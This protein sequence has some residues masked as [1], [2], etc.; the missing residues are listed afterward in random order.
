M[1]FTVDQHFLL[2]FME[3]FKQTY[4]LAD[5]S[6]QVRQLRLT[7]VMELFQ[8]L[9]VGCEVAELGFL[10]GLSDSTR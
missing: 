4:E 5:V 3:A 9:T 8:G 2:S 1:T 10:T 6:V 7:E